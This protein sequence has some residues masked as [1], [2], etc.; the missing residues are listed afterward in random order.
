M[1]VG[2][3]PPSSKRV[4]TASP[5]G[6]DSADKPR[7]DG[8]DKGLSRLYNA[9][10]GLVMPSVYETTSL[11][12]M[13][14]QATGTPVICIDSEGMRE[15]TGHAALMFPRLEPLL[16][17][18]A[19]ARL[20]ADPALRDRLRAEGLASAA[21]FSWTRCAPRPMALLE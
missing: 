15:I 5:K 8:D 19:M 4:A 20:A 21:R 3:S 9:A 14:A 10:E 7:G 16:L 13:E 18:D 2:N 1:V 6:I 11:P 17:S 12:V